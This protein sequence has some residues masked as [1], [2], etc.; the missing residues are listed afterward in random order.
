MHAPP[1]NIGP[2][3]QY[4]L[5]LAASSVRANDKNRASKSWFISLMASNEQLS[6]DCVDV[7]VHGASTCPRHLQPLV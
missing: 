5:L 7:V 6:F 3:V 2:T 1:C 4:T